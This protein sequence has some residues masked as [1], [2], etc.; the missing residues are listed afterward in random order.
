MLG[1]EIGIALRH[2]KVMTYKKIPLHILQIIKIVIRTQIGRLINR[3]LGS[4]YSFSRIIRN[5]ITIYLWLLL[6]YFVR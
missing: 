2:D 1:S 6:F 3:L 4:P 5:V